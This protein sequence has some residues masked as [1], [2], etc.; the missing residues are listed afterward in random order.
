[1]FNSIFS[2]VQ[3]HCKKS[4][5]EG[6]DGFQRIAGDAG[7]STEQLDFYLGCLSEIGVIRYCSKEKTIMLTEKGTRVTRIFPN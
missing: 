1:M 7:V 6:G 4:C 2:I 3:R 5:A